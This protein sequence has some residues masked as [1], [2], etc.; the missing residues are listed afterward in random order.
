MIQ[1]AC[2]SQRNIPRSNGFSLVEVMVAMVIGLIGMLVTLQVYTLFEGQKRATTGGADAMNNGAIALNGLTNDIQKGGYGISS[3]NLVGCSTLLRTGVTLG[4]IAPV[5]INSAT[6]P[7]GDAN[8][9]TL[10]VVYGNNNTAPEG[11]GITSQPGTNSY[12]VATP[13]AYQVNDWVIA[14]PQTRAAPC[15]LDMD[16]VVSIVSPNLN[17]T[18]GEAGMT[19]G[20]LFN[21]GPAP[22]MQVYAIRNGNL[23]VCDYMANDCGLPANTGNTAIWVPIADNI[24]SL[25]AQY[26]QDTNTPMDG[27][28]DVYNQATPTTACG[29]MKTSAIQLALVARN[30]QP[31]KTAVTGVAPVWSGSAATPINLTGT[32]V[33]TG[34]TWQNFRYRVFQTTVPIRNVS[35]KGVQTGC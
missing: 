29:W 22:R 16:Q 28:L 32:T 14:T 31:E 23:T 26:G 13:T 20:M 30:G 24:V 35:W 2:Q 1:F 21:L 17:V 8:T 5:T 7:A 27:I 9:D 18:T 6:I 19:N 11:D 4:T 25:R 15:I 34:F 33:P 3:L 10:V 12:A